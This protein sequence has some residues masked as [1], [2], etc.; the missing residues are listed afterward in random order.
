MNPEEKPARGRPPS[1][2]LQRLRTR[3]WYRSV[4]LGLGATSSYAVELQLDPDNMKKGGDGIKRPRKWDHYEKGRRVPQ[5]A[6]GTQNPIDRAEVQAPGTA[7][8]FRSPIWD[9]LEGKLQRNDVEVALWAH[10]P[11]RSVLFEQHWE[12]RWELAE[13]D[14][15]AVE[16][17]ERADGLDLFELSILYLELSQTINSHDLRIK[18][19]DL[20][21]SFLRRISDIP[22]LD[23]NFG[24]LFDAI[25]NRYKQ[26]LF[27]RSTRKLDVFFPWR[28]ELPDK[29][30]M[31]PAEPGLLD[32]TD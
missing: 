5:D 8:W 10:E 16:A 23:T 17:I 28:S 11:L 6:S 18:A 19:I 1:S 29:A 30:H 26:W 32:W 31:F 4:E 21:F 24:H 3:I 20:Y 13:L 2:E 25:G 15:T 14:D 22:A 9:A 7:R 12:T 27:V